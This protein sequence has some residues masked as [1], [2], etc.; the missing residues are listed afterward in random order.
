MPIKGLTD[1]DSVVPKLPRLGKL[2]KGAEK[3]GN[4]PGEDLPYFRPDF[5]D[6]DV[7]SAFIEAYGEQPKVINVILYYDTLED[8]FPTWI[9]SWDASGMKFRSDGENWVIWRDGSGYKRGRKPHQDDRDQFEVGRFEFLIP[10]LLQKGIYGTVTLETHSNH[11][12]RHISGVLAMVEEQRGGHLRGAQLTMR[13]VLENISVP[14]WGDRKGKRSRADKWLVKLFAPQQMSNLL[15]VVE[16]SDRPALQAT[17]DTD[18]G[19]IIEAEV[20]E[21]PKEKSKQRLAIEARI[22]ELGKVIEA[23]DIECGDIPQLADDMTDDKA[24]EIGKALAGR[25]EEYINALRSEGIVAGLDAGMMPVYD[26]NSS[27]DKLIDEIAALKAMIESVS[28]D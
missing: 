5:N 11:D 19:E 9:E 14:G 1:R 12:L 28:N 6:P 21:V 13:R 4:K 26:K 22:A 17:V 8:T 18:T 25:V 23:A 3:K 2:R 27:A 20:E 7:Q 15:E 24:T 10:E 16:Q